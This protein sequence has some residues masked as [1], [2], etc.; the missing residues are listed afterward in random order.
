LVTRPT[1]DPTPEVSRH[2]GELNGKHRQSDSLS[3]LDGVDSIVAAHGL[4]RDEPV[5]SNDRDF[6][7]VEGLSVVTYLHLVRAYDFGAHEFEDREFSPTG[8]GAAVLYTPSIG[9][10]NSTTSRTATSPRRW[11][12]S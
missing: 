10:A 9:R 5:V 1:V 6:R 4:H 8:G 7:D 11:M 12:S 3:E 2:A